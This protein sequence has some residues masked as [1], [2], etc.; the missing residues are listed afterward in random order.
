MFLDVMDILLLTIFLNTKFVSSLFPFPEYKLALWW[1]RAKDLRVHLA[2]SLRSDL[3][4][5][6]RTETITEGDPG[7][8]Y[9][10]RCGEKLM[11]QHARSY[12]STGYKTHWFS[13]TSRKPRK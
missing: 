13:L 11:H 8:C 7:C 10:K 4:P 3:H 1:L 9:R 6:Q 5:N 2:L 12:W